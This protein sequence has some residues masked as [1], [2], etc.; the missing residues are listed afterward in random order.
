MN[1]IRILMMADLTILSVT[2]FAQSKTESFKVFGNCGMCKKRIEKAALTEGVT[3]AVWNKDTKILTVAYDSAKISNDQIQKNIATVGHDTEKMS[4]DD[5]VY[6]KLPG[7]CL[8]E[9]KKAG[10]NQPA[11]HK[12]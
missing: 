9:R 2:L 1:G 10:T 5:K 12:H 11:H 7:C 8:Y 4:A 3:S 6:D